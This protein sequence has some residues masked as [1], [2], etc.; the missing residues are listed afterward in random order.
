MKEEDLVDVP[1]SA[2]PTTM[3][4]GGGRELGTE[5]LSPGEHGPCRDIDATLGEEL[6]DLPGGERVAQIPAHRGDDDVGWPTVAGGGAARGVGE[7]PVAG[8]AGEALAAA[9]VETIARGGGLVA[10]RAGG[11]RP[12]LPPTLHDFADSNA[13][14]DAR[15][16][17]VQVARMNGPGVRALSKGENRQRHCQAA[18][19]DARRAAVTGA[20]IGRASPRPTRPSRRSRSRTVH[21]PDRQT[22]AR[23]PRGRWARSPRAARR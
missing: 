16:C 14:H 13:L 17:F 19:S 3:P 8:T 15:I 20:R 21:R 10:G 4:P 11:H 1:A 12:T 2:K 7:V 6:G 22:G 9:A 23:R 18:R 5:G